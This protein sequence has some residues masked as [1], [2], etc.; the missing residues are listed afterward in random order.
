[1]A[2]LIYQ[3]EEGVGFLRGEAPLLLSAPHG[4]WQEIPGPDR[5]TLIENGRPAFCKPDGWCAKLVQ[6]VAQ[7]FAEASGLRPYVVFAQVHRAY[8]DP[9]RPPKAGYHPQNPRARQVWERYHCQLRAFVGEMRERFRPSQ[10]LLLDLHGSNVRRRMQEGALFPGGDPRY[11]LL[12]GSLKGSGVRSIAR[13]Q[14]EQGPAVL[15]R[16]GGLRSRLHGLLLG[17]G[18]TQAPLYVWPRSEDDPEPLNGRYL[19]STYGSHR[20]EGLLA[21]QLE[22]SREL[23][24]DEAVRQ[25]YAGL[26][27]QAVWDFLQEIA[28]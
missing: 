9:N 16:P 26:L 25:Q 27:A 22:H 1:M 3:E 18:P 2:T 28:G 11:G 21:L 4:G 20:P 13:L 17:R 6:E 19:L 8:V 5:R 15:Y 12:L 24:A 10:A 14:A 7:A 23:R